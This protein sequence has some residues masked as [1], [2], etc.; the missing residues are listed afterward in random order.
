MVLM[1]VLCVWCV[2]LPCAYLKCLTCMTIFLSIVMTDCC[3]IVLMGVIF[4]DYQWTC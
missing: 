3:N 2:G 4:E 1:L